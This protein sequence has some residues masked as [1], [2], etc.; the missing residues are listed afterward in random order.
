MKTIIAKNSWFVESDLRLD[1][2]F[3][4]SDTN[5]IKLIYR[6]SP[7]QFSTIEKQAQRIFSGNIFKRIY[8][9]DPER[10]VPYITGSDMI[11]S[12]INSGKY[13]SKKQAI[14]LQNLM[15]EKRWILVSCSGSLG[16]TVYTNALFSGR[17]GTHDLIRIIPNNKEVKEGFL[18][19]YLSSKYGYTL[20]TQSSYGGVVKH[21]EPHQ[22]AN[23]PVPIFPTEKQHIIHNLIT[24]SAELRIEA[25]KLLE[26]TDVFFIN[27]LNA[28]YFNV[29]KFQTGTRRISEIQK[30]FQLRF[31]APIY[32]NQGVKL[33]DS[34]K[35]QGFIFDFLGNCDI[36]ISRPG[37]FKRIYVKNNGIPYIVGSD[38]GLNNP[39]A[40]CVYLSKIKT[41]F[42]DELELH[43]NQILITCAG[44]TNVGMVTIITKDFEEQNAIG[45][46]DIIRIKC[47]GELFTQEYV[48]A[49]LRLPFVFDFVKSLKYGSAIERIEPFHVAQIPILRPTEE[50]SKLI[51]KKICRYKE[52][53]YEARKKESQAIQLVENE[54]EKWQQ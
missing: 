6:K 7:Y 49:Y 15:L 2:S 21:I 4:L 38:L 16:N 3:H 32:I 17:I 41:P 30:S 34:F 53:I 50:L 47:S 19:A 26:E 39:F 33:I 27:Y 44:S 28:E 1:A 43:E 12:E 24:E 36:K 14:G 22:I 13:L 45:S 52:C 40:N 18:Y 48:Y 51:T 35:Q 9:S 25:N 8:V 5:R 11:K 37:I 23:I 10:G 46:Q 42:L 31:D 54:I 20:L 29:N